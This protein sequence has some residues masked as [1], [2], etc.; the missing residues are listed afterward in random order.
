M[1]KDRHTKS[2]EECRKISSEYQEQISKLIEE[3]AF[4]L[5]EEKKKNARSIERMG[6]QLHTV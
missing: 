4:E 5:Q 3:H 6:E 2:A 1:W